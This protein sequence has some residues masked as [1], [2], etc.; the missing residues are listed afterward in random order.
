MSHYIAQRIFVFLLAASALLLATAFTPFISE[1][2]AQQAPISFPDGYREWVHV[3]SGTIGS[4]FS[5]Y[6]TE[7][8]IHHVYANATARSGFN[9]MSFEDGS[10]LVYDLLTLSE[11][12]G[13]GTE[14]ARRRVDVMIKDSARF[15]ETGGWRFARFMGEDHEHDVLTPEVRNTCYQCHSK[16]KA[17]GMIFSEFQK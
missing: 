3:K 10:V 1:L 7:G 8:G 9:S 2:H 14:G 13:I 4:E 6:A 15:P 11:K 12:G 17:Q 5:M 16:R